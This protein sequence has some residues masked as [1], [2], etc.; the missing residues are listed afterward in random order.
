ML[1]QPVVHQVQV[2]LM[3]QSEHRVQM[4][5]QQSMIRVEHREHQ[6]L[7]RQAVHQE[8]AVHQDKVQVEHREQAVHQVQVA[9]VVQRVM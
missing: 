4:A 2:E 5:H 3:E 6:E 9:Q 7:I 8:Q 1:L